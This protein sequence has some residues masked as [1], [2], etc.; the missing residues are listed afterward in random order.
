M[1]R[2]GYVIAA[3]DY[4]GLGTPRPHPYLVGVSE[5][6]AVLDSVRAARQLLG[7]GG[8]NRFTVWGHSQGGHAALFTGL[9]AKSYAPDLQLVGVAAAAPATELA[10]LFED[11][12]GS[13]GGNGL[14]AM[15]LWSW[16]RVFGA[17][18]DPVI[19]PSAMPTINRLAGICIESI[20]DIAV[21]RQIERP[22]EHDFLRVRKLDEI[23]PWRSL[24]A[25]NT[26]G[27]LPPDVPIFIAQGLLVRIV[28]PE[29][30]RNYMMHLCKNGSRVKMFIMP[31]TNHGFAA[32][33]S[34]EAAVGWT[35]NRFA[36]LPPPND[37]EA[38][39]TNGKLD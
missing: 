17:P 3:T 18:L 35:A 38:L 33:D 21:R 30:T 2:R 19:D 25:L 20:F 16:A 15:T 10:I 31:K 14:V 34:A 36:G 8:A 4:P 28:R 29:V 27:A 11:D 13:A 32:R 39:E 23:A 12:I 26:P 5:A 22:L 6:R 7:I 9:L 24:L 1:V 37:C